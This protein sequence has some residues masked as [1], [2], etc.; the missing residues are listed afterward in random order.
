[1]QCINRR[2]TIHFIYSAVFICQYYSWYVQQS[3]DNRYCRF[4]SLSAALASKMTTGGSIVHYT[5]II[6]TA[7]L[8]SFVARSANMS[9]KLTDWK[10]RIT[11]LQSHR[12]MHF[13]KRCRSIGIRSMW[14]ATDDPSEKS[15]WSLLLVAVL[16]TNRDNSSTH[17]VS[18]STKRTTVNEFQTNVSGPVVRGEKSGLPP[19]VGSL[20]RT[21]MLN[22]SRAASIMKSLF[23]RV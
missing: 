18:G 9:S 19:C 15:V 22:S 11:L 17:S 2:E 10:N 20:V 12:V 7:L 1:M 16:C 3:D 23:V 5:V 13:L 6:L 8:Y 4:V 21:G 14:L